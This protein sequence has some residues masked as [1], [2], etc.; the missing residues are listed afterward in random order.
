MPT[1][2]AGLSG[3]VRSSFAAFCGPLACRP[4]FGWD[5]RILWPRGPVRGHRYDSWRG[6]SENA[7]RVIG[8][9]KLHAPQM[10]PREESRAVRRLAEVRRVKAA[11]G[12]A[13]FASDA[14][15]P[16][17][18]RHVVALVS[19]KALQHLDNALLRAAAHIAHR[20]W[21]EYLD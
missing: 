5:A 17:I 18:A 11:V 21:R 4:S 2:C 7:L 20:K 12:R 3:R 8:K 13:E 19:G 14:D 6:R 9:P 15:A 16:I 1:P 10:Q